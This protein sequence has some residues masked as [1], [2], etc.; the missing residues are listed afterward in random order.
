MRYSPFP[1]PTFLSIAWFL[2]GL[3]LGG[4][5]L[6]SLPTVRDSAVCAEERALEVD[7]DDRSDS[8]ELDLA[9]HHQ[10]ETHPTSQTWHEVQVFYSAHMHAA[11]PSANLQ[12]GPPCL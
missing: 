12:R 8:F 7:D 11:I 5:L 3:L 1:R 4:N 2:T 10:V 6:S 9:L